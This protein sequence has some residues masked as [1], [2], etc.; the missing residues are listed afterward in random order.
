M[1]WRTMRILS[2]AC[3]DELLAG[4]ARI[5]RH[6]QHQVELVQH[7]VEDAKRRGGIEHQS[8]PAAALVDQPDGAVDVL[9]CLRME[10]DDV[11]AGL[12]EIGN[13]AVDRLHHEMDVDYRLGRGPQR[14]AHASHT[15]GPM[16]RFGT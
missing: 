7:V 13:D 9:A 4:E 3:G 14:L 16:V 12:G 15:I 8:R 10:T 1:R 6:D 2:S 5:D 11:G